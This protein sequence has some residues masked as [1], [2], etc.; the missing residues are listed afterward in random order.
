MRNNLLVMLLALAVNAVS[1]TQADAAFNSIVRG[2][3]LADLGGIS[4]QSP[5]RDVVFEG[6]RFLPVS[7]SCLIFLMHPR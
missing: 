6:I 5:Q 4:M 3:F 1:A 7:L 2:V